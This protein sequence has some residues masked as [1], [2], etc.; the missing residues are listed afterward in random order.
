MIGDTFKNYKNTYTEITVPDDEIDKK[1][2][3]LSDIL[4]EQELPKSSY[5]FMP[6]G[7]AF[8][9]A[10]VVLLVITGSFAQ[11]AKPG[12]LLY[13]VHSVTQ[14]VANRVTKVFQPKADHVN[15][16]KIHT[17]VTTPQ[18]LPTPTTKPSITPT[19]KPK[20]IEEKQESS[21]NGNE[22]KA[23]PT[24]KVLGTHTENEESHGTSPT[25]F[26]QTVNNSTNGNSKESENNTNNN[27]GNNNGNS[28]NS[29]NSHGNKGNN[30]K[31]DK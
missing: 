27:H 17:F 2:Q 30:E 13:P 20:G 12:S 15:L 26:Q 24:T 10:F 8:V 3:V 19:P 16:P 29:E 11:S 6:Y 18:L 28:G 9:G 1:W 7:A 22:H 14:E 21:Q 4:P 23:I 25:I 5:H 31:N